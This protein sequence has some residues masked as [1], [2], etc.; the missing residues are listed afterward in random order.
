MRI[1]YY[2][3]FPHGHIPN[4]SYDAV[5]ASLGLLVA[6]IEIYVKMTCNI[7]GLDKTHAPPPLIHV[8]AYRKAS[9]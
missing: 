3:P 5:V 1:L 4:I 8:D 9:C 6:E 2:I 7:T